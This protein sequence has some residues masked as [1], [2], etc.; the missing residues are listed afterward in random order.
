MLIGPRLIVLQNFTF[1]CLTYLSDNLEY[2]QGV[3]KAMQTE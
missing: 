2:E 3:S 1:P